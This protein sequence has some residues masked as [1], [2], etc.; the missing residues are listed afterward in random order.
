MLNQEGFQ[1]HIPPESIALLD[2]TKMTL[3]GK[4]KIIRSLFVIEKLA[5]DLNY[6]TIKR[7]LYFIIDLSLRGIHTIR[8]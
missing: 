6:K 1:Q 7:F 3:A 8:N 5:R 2:S 4:S